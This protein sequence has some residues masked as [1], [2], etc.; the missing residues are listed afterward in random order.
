MLICTILGY[1]FKSE[2]AIRNYLNAVKTL[3]ILAR[4]EPPDLKDI[5]MS[6]TL[7]GLKKKL[8][9]STRR[10]QPLTPE[11]LTDILAYLDLESYADVV[12]WVMLLIGFFAMLRKSNLVSDTIGGFDP[13]KQLTRG[14]VEFV[15][16]EK[17][18]KEGRLPARTVQQP[19]HEVGRCD[20]RTS[21]WGPR[22][23][24]SGSRGL[25]I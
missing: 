6:I 14:H 18:V 3:H 15:E 21:Q 25:G 16:T 8:A 23:I 10:A 17:Y 20:F 7:K 2:K 4:V 19:F 13:L 24:D 12:F 22:R 5:E 1:S 9:R 11:I